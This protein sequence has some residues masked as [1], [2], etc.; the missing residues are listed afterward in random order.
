MKKLDKSIESL[1]VQRSNSEKSVDGLIAQVYSSDLS[2][3]KERDY[4]C[5]IYSTKGYIE[6]IKYSLNL[7]R[8]HFRN[9]SDYKAF[10]SN[11]YSDL[12]NDENFKD[13]IEEVEKYFDLKSYIL[14]FKKYLVFIKDQHEE[15]VKYLKNIEEHYG[16][17]ILDQVM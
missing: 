14:D 7:I 11:Q 17:E 1:C 12:L 2:N 3:E 6:G 9:N 4:F 10:N 15:N 8:D 13:D 16:F 5:H